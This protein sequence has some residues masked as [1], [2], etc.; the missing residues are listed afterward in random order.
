M[1]NT[2]MRREWSSYDV[3]IGK[4]NKKNRAASPS[5]TAP[6]LMANVRMEEGWLITRIGVFLC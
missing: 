3:G 4:E 6:R 5:A 1:R 2:A